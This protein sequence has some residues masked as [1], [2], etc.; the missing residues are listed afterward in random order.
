M[1]NARIDGRL[2]DEARPVEIQTDF[3]PNAD[4]SALIKVGETQVICTATVNPFVP[5]W[6]RGQGRGWVSAEY[7]M[8]PS[9]TGERIDRRRAATSGRTKEIERLIGRSLRAVTD[10]EKLGE[11]TV[12]VDCDVLRADGGTRTAAITGG[13]V[14]L[15]LALQQISGRTSVRNSPLT[16][17]VSAISVGIVDGDPMIDLD[18]L[19]DSRAEVDMNVVMTGQGD[20]V[21]LQG[22]AEGIPFTNSQ[23]DEMLE[24]ARL[25]CGS[26]MEAQQLA[27]QGARR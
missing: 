23:L 14:A 3:M 12:T 5:P 26:M 10:M 16:N 25:G 22:T 18:Y 27:L 15:A 9:S 24:L 2:H 4:G 21:E 17:T 11:R 19:E 13:F 6:M 7:G 8:L 20:F 1:T